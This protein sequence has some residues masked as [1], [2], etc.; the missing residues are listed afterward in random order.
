MLDCSPASVTG[1]QL[2]AA[3]DAAARWIGGEKS[4]FYNFVKKIK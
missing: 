4:G 2:S 3:R 1:T